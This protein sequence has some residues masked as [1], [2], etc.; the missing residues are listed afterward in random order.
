[1]E[2][3]KQL[4]TGLKHGKIIPFVGAGVS[5]A[6]RAKADN[7]QLFPG[8]P[9]LLTAAA[10][11]LQEESKPDDA[12][13]VRILAGKNR[14]LEAAQEAQC[15]HFLNADLIAAGLSPFAPETAA[16]KAGRLMLQEMAECV[17]RETS[18]A[19]ETTLSGLS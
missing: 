16:F 14:L 3:P 10:Q 9:A 4:E 12:E 6:V 11:R 7:Q 19:F 5:M 15:L 13:L 8:W 2:I 17:N 1:M 18:F